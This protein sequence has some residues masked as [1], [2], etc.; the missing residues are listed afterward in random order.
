M[1]F[2]HYISNPFPSPANVD[3]REPVYGKPPRIDPYITETGYKQKKY[4]N[5]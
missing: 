4:L 5:I 2:M 3:A 1:Y